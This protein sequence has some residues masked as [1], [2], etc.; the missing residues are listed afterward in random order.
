[1]TRSNEVGI[2]VINLDRAP[3][4][5]EHMTALLGRLG[6][7]FTRI[8]AVDARLLDDGEMAA[9]RK[10]AVG[11]GLKHTWSASQIGI[12]L[13]HMKT[14][15]A[16]SMAEEE[17]AVVF[18][19][20]VHLSEEIKPLLEDLSWVNSHMDV[21]R[22]ETT[23]QSMKLED[24]PSSAV[25]GRRIFEVKSA[26]WGAAGYL[27]RKD[28]ARWIAGSPA[29]IYEPVDWFLFHPKSALTPTLRVFQLDPAPCVQDQYHHRPAVRRNFEKETRDP[30]SWTEL[31]RDASK[32]LLSP[33]AR[34]IRN[35]RGVPFS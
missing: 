15:N 10:A 14:W 30:T 1:M 20:D 22:L 35:M 26:A 27:V 21:V 7:S 9:F 17:L 11:K 4:R 31:T 12:F 16:I 23:W 29:H 5:L 25:R 24:Q 2:Y 33:V 34:R 6:L 28:I 32:R 3:D 18:E 13:S 8:A 19:D